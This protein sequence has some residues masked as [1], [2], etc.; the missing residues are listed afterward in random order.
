MV[1]RTNFIVS[2][3]CFFNFSKITISVHDFYVS[4]I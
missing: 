4:N 1:S 2:L 3:P